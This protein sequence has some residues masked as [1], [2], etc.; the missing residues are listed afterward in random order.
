M[1]EREKQLEELSEKGIPTSEVDLP[2]P[3]IPWVCLLR[4]HAVSFRIDTLAK[5]R[6]RQI[7]TRA[8]FMEGSLSLT[9][10]ASIAYTDVT[11]DL[12]RLNIISIDVSPRLV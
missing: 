11:T 9:Q 5:Y 6:C 3:S 8:D 12:D 10:R 1:K 7:M 4:F 2:L